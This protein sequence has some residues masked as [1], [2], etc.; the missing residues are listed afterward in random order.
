MT[1]Y[2]CIIVSNKFLCCRVQHNVAWMEKQFVDILNPY[3]RNVFLRELVG[4][5]NSWTPN[6]HEFQSKNT[7]IKAK[8]TEIKK[9]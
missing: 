5:Q 8:K 3:V 1:T 7:T 6:F 9:T 2:L 4:Q